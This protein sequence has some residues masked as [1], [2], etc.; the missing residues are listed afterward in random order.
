MSKWVY[1][2]LA[3][4]GIY[5]GFEILK[6]IGAKT[7][8][9]VVDV[10][11]GWR[12]IVKE[13]RS[14]DLDESDM[15]IIDNT[16]YYGLIRGFPL[17]YLLAEMDVESNFDPHAES[18]AGAKGLL[19]IKPI[20]A[21]DTGRSEFPTDP[22]ELARCGIDYLELQ[23]NRVKHDIQRGYVQLLSGERVPLPKNAGNYELG[24][25]SMCYYSRDQYIEYLQ[26]LTTDKDDPKNWV[27]SSITAARYAAIVWVQYQLWSDY[28][29]IA[30]ADV[31][32]VTEANMLL[33]V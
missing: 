25:T 31:P 20:A 14:V 8:I 12:K 17:S 19:Q 16:L 28:F 22:L 1:V 21:Y 11:R 33:Y 23:R 7:L 9:G 3:C 24:Y 4:V 15:N 29:L 5:F 10:M 2:V 27:K 6:K 18:S 30:R 13:E 32:D 26:Q